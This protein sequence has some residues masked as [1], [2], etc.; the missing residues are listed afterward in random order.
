MA[1]F[2][3]SVN[4]LLETGA[5]TRRVQILTSD[6]LTTA[7]TANWL[8]LTSD[9]QNLITPDGSLNPNVLTP[10]DV[11]D[12]RYNYDEA[13]GTSSLAQVTPTISGTN[14][15]LAV[16]DG[17]Q[18]VLAPTSLVTGNL[19]QA[20]GNKSIEDAGFSLLAGTTAAYGGGGSSNAYAVTGITATSIVTAAVLASTNSV[21]I[22]KVVPSANTLTVTFN[23]DPG[24]GTT[25]NYIALTPTP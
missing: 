24:A 17:A 4:Y 19:V 10:N 21:A 23:A 11:I 20:A 13:T 6:S 7:V 15:T 9:G 2:N 12:I 8:T 1:Y 16:N 14:I 18:G 22:T 3:I 5:N 25:V